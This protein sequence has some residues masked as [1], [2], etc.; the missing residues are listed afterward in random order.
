M[1]TISLIGSVARSLAF[2][3]PT[4]IGR[5]KTL[6]DNRVR[7]PFRVFGSGYTRDAFD[8]MAFQFRMGAG[9]LFVSP[10]GSNVK[11]LPPMPANPT[12]IDFFNLRFG[13]NTT[14]NHC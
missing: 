2:G 9:F 14:R 1:K 13:A 4:I 3:A 11:R 12:L 10:T 8:P 5:R 7:T 6:D